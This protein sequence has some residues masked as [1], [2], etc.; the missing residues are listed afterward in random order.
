MPLCGPKSFHT[1]VISM[2]HESAEKRNTSTST[3]S[4]NFLTIRIPGQQQ[5]IYTSFYSF[6]PVRAHQYCE[7][8]DLPEWYQG[9]GV[10][11]LSAVTRGAVVQQSCCLGVW[12]QLSSASCRRYVKREGG[13]DVDHCVWCLGLEKRGRPAELR[14]SLNH[15]MPPGMEETDTKG[16]MGRDLQNKRERERECV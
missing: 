1:K 12:G 13:P 14:D 3:S 15:N 16:Q 7:G 10:F 9:A 5:I 4:L 11:L 6:L 2:R 8:G